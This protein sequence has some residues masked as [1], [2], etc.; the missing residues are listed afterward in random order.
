MQLVALLPGRAAADRA[1]IRLIETGIPPDDIVIVDRRTED[2]LIE[3][4]HSD[5]RMSFWA[6]VRAMQKSE[7]DITAIDRK[8]RRGAC[9]LGVRASDDRLATVS[10]LL[11]KSGARQQWSR[12]TVPGER[13]DRCSS[14]R[15][16]M[17]AKPPGN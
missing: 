6:H 11:N 17:R 8:V 15:R 7:R 2:F 13:D 9:L 4:E 10:S 3:D 14:A 5:S 1:R 16:G 12:S